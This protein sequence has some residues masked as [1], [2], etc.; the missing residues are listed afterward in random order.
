MNYEPSEEE[1]WSVTVK[2]VQDVGDIVE[3]FIEGRLNRGPHAVAVV[4]RL[5]DF[6]FT[7]PIVVVQWPWSAC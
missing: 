6:R 5:G 4:C 2:V 7:T 3:K 1:L